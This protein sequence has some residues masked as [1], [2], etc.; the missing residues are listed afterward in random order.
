MAMMPPTIVVA[1]VPTVVVAATAVMA[2]PMS[3]PVAA[4]DLNDCRIGAAQR[5]GCCC[6]HGR[7]GHSWRECKST[8]G[9]SEYQEPFHFSA[10]S[11]AASALCGKCAELSLN[12]GDGLAG[13]AAAV[14]G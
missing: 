9:K 3:V 12:F 7:R 13:Q 4:F 11:F 10:S 2:P 1:A 14:L 8:A 6:G 5:M